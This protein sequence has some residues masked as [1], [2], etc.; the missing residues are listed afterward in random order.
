MTDAARITAFPLSMALRQMCRSAASIRRTGEAAFSIHAPGYA[1]D[2]TAWVAIFPW[3][4]RITTSNIWN[5]GT[6]SPIRNRHYREPMYES[7]PE[8]Y[9]WTTGYADWSREFETES[10][11]HRIAARFEAARETRALYR[12]VWTNTCLLMS[13]T[14]YGQAWTPTA[15]YS[16]YD[17]AW[18]NRSIGLALQDEIRR[19]IGLGCSACVRLSAQVFDYADYLPVPGQDHS[20]QTDH[21]A[22]PRLGVNWRATPRSRCMPITRQETWLR[23]HRA[24]HS[25]AA[26]LR[27][28]RAGNSRQG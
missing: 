21:S 13:T 3:R 12:G 25:M 24:A 7:Y 15:D 16:V 26:P 17:Q 18:S 14:V 23:C 22:T 8:Q 9:R 5:T 19:G 6:R 27:R 20:I 2:A 10:L 1:L 4:C 28:W 11:T